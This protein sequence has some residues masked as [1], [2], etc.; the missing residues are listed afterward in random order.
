[1]LGSA[2]AKFNLCAHRFEQLALCLNVANLGDVLED[3]LVFS[4]NGGGHTRQR[5][6]L[7]AGNFNG[8]EEGISSAN[9]EFVHPL[10]LWGLRV[11]M[12]GGSG[13][14]RRSDLIEPILRALAVQNRAPSSLILTVRI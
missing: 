6:I 11:E 7:S 2:V 9:D 12:I 1:M 8:A 5:R 10:S 4:E 13:S 3:Y 14:V